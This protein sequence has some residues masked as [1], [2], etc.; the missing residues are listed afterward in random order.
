MEK[1]VRAE[2]ERRATVLQARASSSQILRPRATA[3]LILKRGEAKREAARRGE[4]QAIKKVFEAIHEARRLQAAQLSVPEMLPKLAEGEANS[5]DRA[6]RARQGVEA[7][8]GVH[9]DEQP[10][11]PGRRAGRARGADGAATRRPVAPPS[12]APSAARGKRSRRRAVTRTRRRF[13]RAACRPPTALRRRT[14]SR[15]KPPFGA[16]PQSIAAMPAV[17]KGT[18]RA[19]VDR[20]R[21]LDR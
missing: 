18:R 7:S 1:Q 6:Q 12:A 8:R 3:V 19:S 16:G 10:G 2:R 4:A 15:G 21:T 17:G 9:Q 20:A 11:P 5:V 13:V 14:S